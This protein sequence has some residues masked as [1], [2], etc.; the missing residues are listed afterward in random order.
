M[1]GAVIASA[2]GVAFA[3]NILH[4]ALSLLFTL[5]GVGGI[6]IFLNADFL[7]VTQL[8][9]YV[10]GVLVLILFAVMLTSRIR[11]QK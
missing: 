10:G 9:L 4:A 8:L 5:L 11:D 3:R 2:A 7:A 6:F 1:A